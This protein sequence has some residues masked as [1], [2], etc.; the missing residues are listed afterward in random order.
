MGRNSLVLRVQGER[1]TWLL[2]CGALVKAPTNDIQESGR[3]SQELRVH[4][5]WFCRS[6]VIHSFVFDCSRLSLCI[7]FTGCAFQFFYTFAHSY[8]LMTLFHSFIFANAQGT[9]LRTGRVAISC[10]RP[11]HSARNIARLQL[12]QSPGSHSLSLQDLRHGPEN[13]KSCY[14]MLQAYT[15]CEECCEAPSLSVSRI[16][17][18]GST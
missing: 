4:Q 6:L 16:S 1:F 15:F 12:F 14:I 3:N 7:F 18:S 5:V 8:L 11:T 10:F 9:D 2:L 13:R 17:F